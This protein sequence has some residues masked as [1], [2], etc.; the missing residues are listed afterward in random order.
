MHVLDTS[1]ATPAA[2]SRTWFIAILISTMHKFSKKNVQEVDDGQ[3]PP[4]VGTDDESDSPGSGA[5]TP[6]GTIEGKGAL[7]AGHV[8]AVKAGGRRRKAPRKG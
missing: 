3:N 5:A 1:S 7:Q 6:N 2:I 8:A 4:V